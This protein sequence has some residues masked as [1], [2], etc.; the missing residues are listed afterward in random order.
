MNM[1]VLRCITLFSLFVLLFASCIEPNKP[2]DPQTTSDY[3]L[4]VDKAFV[5]ADGQD[6]VKFTL[7]NP[8]AED[9]IQ[10]ATILQD[11]KPLTAPQ[12][13]TSKEGT[14]TFTAQINGKQ[15]GNDIKISTVEA[16]DAH[17][18][19]KPRA[20]LEIFTGVW[21]PNC[22]MAH[23]VL[24]KALKEDLYVPISIHQDGDGSKDPLAIPSGQIIFSNRAL[25]A[26]PAIIY[27]FDTKLKF[28][29]NA[30][31]QTYEAIKQKY[32]LPKRSYV[33]I[34]L[35]V[36]VIDNQVYA[37]TLIERHAQ[38]TE[39]LYATVMLYQDNL[40][41]DQNNYLGLLPGASILKNFK[42]DHVLVQCHEDSTTPQLIPFENNRF[43]GYFKFSKKIDSAKA[44]DYGVIVVLSN[45][46]DGTSYQVNQVK[47][48]QVAVVQ[49]L[50]D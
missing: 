46:L 27:N 42:H 25:D 14:Y 35:D 3:R 44:A 11:G 31:S 13:S 21:C 38:E 37:Y 50:A 26:V 2:E 9:Y 23:P 19:Y 4:L 22:P 47:S 8:N 30:G 34:A 33:G 43:N 1:R 24:E 18:T 32:P 45:R 15:V 29:G 39:P 20:F 49:K 12:F 7:T 6:A 41:V 16:A 40:L 48:A 10:K 28:Y 5:V 36:K 17:R